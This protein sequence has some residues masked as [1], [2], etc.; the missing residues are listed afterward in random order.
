M[1]VFFV[2]IMIKLKTFLWLI[3]IV[4]LLLS[5]CGPTY[6][7]SVLLTET[8]FD[9]ETSGIMVGVIELENTPASIILS[10][11]VRDT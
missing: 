1:I 7:R 10:V 4:F 6:V 9:P 5:A 11:R 8:K 2:T 3:T